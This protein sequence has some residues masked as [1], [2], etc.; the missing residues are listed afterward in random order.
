MRSQGL[1]TLGSRGRCS[2][3]TCRGTPSSCP[4]TSACSECPPPPSLC[5]ALLRSLLSVCVVGRGL[6]SRCPG[7]AGAPIVHQCLSL[8][9]SLC[10]VFSAWEWPC[11]P[12]LLLYNLWGLCCFSPP[13]CVRAPLQFQPGCAGLRHSPPGISTH[14]AWGLFAAWWQER[15]V[16]VAV[17]FLLCGGL[18][19]SFINYQ[20]I[21][22]E[23][24]L[25]AIHSARVSGDPMGLSSPST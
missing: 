12:A 11:L 16:L 14:Q 19:Y 21:V 13:Q 6:R 25:H 24:L 15:C 2:N 10:I 23:C 20:E 22:L 1:F 4:L 17:V 7:L 9:L 3:S 18:I 8:S 5:L